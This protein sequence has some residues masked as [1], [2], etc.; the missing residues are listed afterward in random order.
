MDLDEKDHFANLAK[1]VADN[2]DQTAF[3]TLFDHFAPRLK[4]WLVKRSM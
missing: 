3:A 2:R 4:S 1:A